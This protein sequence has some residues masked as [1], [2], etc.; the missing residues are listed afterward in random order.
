MIELLVVVA[1]IAVLVAIL[2]PALGRA[3]EQARRTVCLSNQR[4][5]ATAL[6]QYAFDQKDR[7][8]YQVPGVNASYTYQ[9]Y[10]ESWYFNG[11]YGLGLLFKTKLVQD[12]KFLYC[13]SQKVPMLRYPFGWEYAWMAGWSNSSLKLCGYWYRVTSEVRDPEVK[14]SELDYLN[15]LRF[16]SMEYPMVL[17]MDVG[18]VQPYFCSSEDDLWAHRSPEAMNV[19]FSDGHAES[20]SQPA[21]VV[22]LSK[23]V[24]R[25]T[26]IDRMDAYTFLLFQAQDKKDYARLR[27]WGGSF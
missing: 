12:P 27:N 17:S 5:I 16:G 14:Q 2:L 21:D 26:G 11:W 23:K 9:V 20:V 25:T 3:R 7:F 18:M 22:A 10:I 24:F 15:N 4:Q 13:P 1:I 19:A 8:P 6:V